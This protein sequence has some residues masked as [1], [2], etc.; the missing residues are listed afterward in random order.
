MSAA[1]DGWTEPHNNFLSQAKEN[2]YR[3]LYRPPYMKNPNY[4]TIGSAFGFL[5]YIK[6]LV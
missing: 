6:D 2:A 5:I 4:F 3:V 1:G